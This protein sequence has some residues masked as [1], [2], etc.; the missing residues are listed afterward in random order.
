M[1]IMRPLLGQLNQGA[2]FT[3]AQAARY[4]PYPVLGLVL[5]ARCDLAQNKFPVLNYLP[6][7]SLDAWMC[8]DGCD[9]LHSRAH[10]DIYSS[11]HNALDNA[12]IS[13]SVLN[14]KSPRDI[15]H[16]VFMDAS[17]DKGIKNAASRFAEIVERI[18][19]LDSH[20]DG[21]GSLVRLY[22]SFDKLRREMLKEL[23][24]NRLSGYYFL[25]RAYEDE[26]PTGYVVLMREVAH[27]PRAL[28]TKISRGLSEGDACFTTYPSWTH[29]LSFRHEDFAMPIGEMPSPEIEHVL[30]S[31][32]FL[33]GRIGLPDPDT[34]YLADVCA[35]RPPQA[36]DGP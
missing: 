24:L 9:I 19:L 28:A 22:G 11:L 25:P 27:L 33:F 31:F 18:E 16:A 1:K 29:H 2:L 8:V 5:T 34:G 23:V 36:G 21:N 13:R 35:R 30:Q 17:V 32:S 26:H 4:A 12:G 15:L 10:S 3:C 20:P 6:V 14:S 7:V